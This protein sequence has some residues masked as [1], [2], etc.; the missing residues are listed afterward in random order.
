ME[1][2]VM[3]YVFIYGYILFTCGMLFLLG[4]IVFSWVADTTQAP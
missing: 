3:D 2:K 1:N 4:L